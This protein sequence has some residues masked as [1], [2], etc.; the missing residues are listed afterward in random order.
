MND[1]YASVTGQTIKMSIPHK[2]PKSFVCIAFY[3]SNP[4]PILSYNLN[5]IGGAMR[6]IGGIHLKL[7]ICR[8]VTCVS[9]KILF[10]NLIF[11]R[12]I[13]FVDNER[14]T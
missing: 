12:R 7:C 5:S 11:I 3:E 6:Y 9:G 2:T 13:L 1:A 10:R 8:C 14:S 4:R